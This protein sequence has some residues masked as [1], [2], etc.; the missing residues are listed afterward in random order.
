MCPGTV[1][2]TLASGPYRYEIE[3]GRV[4]S[5]SRSP[6]RS[7]WPRAA[8]RRRRPPRPPAIDDVAL[9]MRA[10]DLHVAPVI[11]SWN[12]HHLWAWKAAARS[13]FCDAATASAT[14]ILAGDNSAAEALLCF[15]LW[16]PLDIA[17]ASREHP[18]PLQFV[19]AALPPQPTTRAGCTDM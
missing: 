4:P 16:E 18:S 8:A 14:T 7:L 15:D 3:R 5:T 11:T 19:A 9:L 1:G 6:A 2:L 10:E 13:T 17:G 12:R